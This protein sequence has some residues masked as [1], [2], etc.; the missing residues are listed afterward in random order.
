M[1]ALAREA[2]AS[3]RLVYDHFPDLPSLYEAFF[4]DRVSHY[5]DRLDEAIESPE[6][7]GPVVGAFTTLLSVP[8]EDQRAIRLLIAD[9]ATPELDV[10]RARLR[11]RLESRWMT[12]FETPETTGQTDRLLRAVLWTA[13]GTVLTL[14]D[15][16][17]R[18]ELTEEEATALA[19]AT[20]QALAT[21]A[22]ART[23][24][25]SSTDSTD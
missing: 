6:T 8:R 12:R 1:A 9:T 13:M 16:A 21:T 20:A 18:G 3:R 5:I 25:P 24:N 23:P 7:A 17:S 10:I 22:L 19:V 2:G 15:L 4:D 11:A 14:A